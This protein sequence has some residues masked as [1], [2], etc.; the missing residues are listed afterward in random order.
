MAEENVVNVELT[1]EH[2]TNPESGNFGAG[3]LGEA[4]RQQAEAAKKQL[5]TIAGA[6]VSAARTERAELASQKASLQEAIKKI[7]K[8]E[9][10]LAAAMA[11]ANGPRGVLPLAATVGSKCAVMDFMRKNGVVVP[12]SDSDVWKVE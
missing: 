11:Q 6:I 2:V 7:E 10:V 3:V 9:A 8:R 1:I 12:P 4:L 5:V